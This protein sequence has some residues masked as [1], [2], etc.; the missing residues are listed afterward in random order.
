MKYITTLH[1]IQN[2]CLTYLFLNTSIDID[3]L[4]SLLNVSIVKYGNFFHIYQCVI[5]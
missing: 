1:N 3:L 2:S 5:N 4:F